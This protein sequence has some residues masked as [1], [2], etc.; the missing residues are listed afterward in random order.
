[1]AHL[2]LTSKITVDDLHCKGLPRSSMKPP[3]SVPAKKLNLD[4]P[5]KDHGVVVVTRI[6]R[7]NEV[8]LTAATGGTEMSCYRCT[9]PF[10]VVVLIAGIVVTAVAY[11]FN[12]HGSIISVLGL[13][14]LSAGLGL[15]GCSAICWRVRQRRKKTDKRR[16]SQTALIASQ[17]HC[18]A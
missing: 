14:L 17:G 16:E 8:Q 5:T 2:F 6:P 11:T 1:M 4:E 3:V 13:A 18:M 15:L 7:I 9:V 12:S 10:G